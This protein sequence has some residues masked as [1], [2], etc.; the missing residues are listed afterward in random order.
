M[1]REFELEV[2]R[3]SGAGK[4]ITMETMQR[5]ED[6]GLPPYSAVL[7]A[8]INCI[9]TPSETLPLEQQAQLHVLMKLWIEERAELLDE[10]YPGS[11]NA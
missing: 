6:A 4:M 1:D 10:Q 8:L 9:F 2:F 7:A 11:S 3:T 5:L